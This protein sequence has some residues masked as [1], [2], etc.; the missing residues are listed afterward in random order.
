MPWAKIDMGR[1]MLPDLRGKIGIPDT[2]SIRLDWRAPTA[3]D[4][5]AAATDPAP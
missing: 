1:R 4:F 3:Y 5:S 2:A